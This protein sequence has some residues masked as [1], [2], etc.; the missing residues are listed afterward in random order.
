MRVVKT[1]QKDM[2]SFNIEIFDEVDTL[3]GDGQYNVR[4]N[5]AHVIIYSDET[6]EIE[7]DIV[8]KIESRELQIN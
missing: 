7:S 1:N 5:W 4:T 8:D 6:G 2:D 3:I